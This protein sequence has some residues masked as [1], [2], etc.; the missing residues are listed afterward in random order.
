MKNNVFKKLKV[1]VGIHGNI[2]FLE[3]FPDDEHHAYMNESLSDVEA[4]SAFNDASG[5]YLAE[6]RFDGGQ[7][8]RHDGESDP[9]LEIVKIEKIP[10]G[11]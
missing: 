5:I 2:V 11:E 1:A 10:G 3:E 4:N 6:L 8:T 9:Y 7:E